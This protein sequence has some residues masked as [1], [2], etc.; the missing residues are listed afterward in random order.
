MRHE[1]L[2]A[3]LARELR[4]KQTDAEKL[5][6]YKIRDRQLYGCKFRR[7]QPFDS[8]VVDFVC[9]EQQLIVE[10]DGGQHSEALI[11]A[12]DEQRTRHLEAKGYRIL[13]F[14][15]TDVIQN[16]EGVLEKIK[17]RVT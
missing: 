14:W 9:Q 17:E 16:M 1:K 4:Q 12:A 7:Q 6:W 8:Y 3:S 13:R 2:P 10:I 15:N 5:L 11:K